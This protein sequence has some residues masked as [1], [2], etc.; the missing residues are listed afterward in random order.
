MCN[1]L[2]LIPAVLFLG[3]D[4]PNRDTSQSLLADLLKTYRQI[5][6]PL[7]PAEAELVR[8]EHGWSGVIRGKAMPQ[9]S[10]GFLLR[11]ATKDKPPLLLV[12]T[13][14]YEPDGKEVKIRS[15]KPTGT[16]TQE[17]H[18]IWMDA[19]FEIN[20]GLATAL[21]CKAR[22]WD[23]LAQALW[24]ESLGMDAGHHR[25][26]F[27][28]P[29]KLSSASALYHVA[30]VHWANDLVRPGTDRA[31]ILTRME[32]LLDAEPALATQ[33]NKSLLHS[34]KLALVP[35]KAKPGSVEALI[36]DL[37]NQVSRDDERY[38]R[39]ARLGFAAVP[40]LLDHLDDERMTRTVQPGFMNSPPRIVLVHEIV[41]DLLRGLAG[42]EA[43]R[44]W[45]RRVVTNGSSSWPL[46]KQDVI[47]WWRSVKNIDE[48]AYLA[49]HVLS[50][51]PTQIRLNRSNLDLLA[52]KYPQ[53]L[54]RIYR[55]ILDERPKVEPWEVVETIAQSS[56]P[57]DKKIELLLL[58]ATHKNLEHQAAAL[59]M[60]SEL[61]HRRFVALLI[62]ALNGLPNTP[63]IP[64]WRCPEAHLARLVIMTN[65]RIAWQVREKVAK[66]SVVGLRMEQIDDS[67]SDP[68]LHREQRL[69][70]LAAFLD[71]STLRDAD[72]DPNAYEHLYAG[73]GFS[74]MEVRNFAALQI[75]SVVG[76]DFKTECLKDLKPEQWSTL[77]KLV[78]QALE[79][80]G[81]VMQE[82][83]KPTN[84]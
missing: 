36:D 72:S 28:Q 49:D 51:D 13:E 2:Y 25:G 71:D 57:K 70:F 81:I 48:E 50:D 62:K 3:V 75:A 41:A 77:R 46:E 43:S 30:W 19:T 24:D 20:A 23:K 60:L 68:K 53:H 16:L 47:A 15:V 52:K 22:G 10:L 27:V 76:I 9:D 33:P 37:S 7:P 21:Q 17:T 65:D 58:G 14:Q 11:A 66:R 39:I 4:E 6:L 42:A 32:A 40:A 78:R 56:L 5:G 79:R 55:T 84:K 38:V 67:H 26:I 1:L 45:R 80:E 64:Y 29:A 74:K 59:S 8:F 63:K 69:K 31:A 82:S 44:Q 18:P 34:L 83:E 12:G 61:D 35:S 54:E 73:Y